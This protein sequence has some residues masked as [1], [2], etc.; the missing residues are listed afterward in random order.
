MAIV[1]AASSWLVIILI[2]RAVWR[3]DDRRFDRLLFER[4][5]LGRETVHRGPRLANV[6][7]RLGVRV[8]RGLHCR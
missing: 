6:R 2:V 8:G 7:H 1:T 3:A 5:G 4:Y